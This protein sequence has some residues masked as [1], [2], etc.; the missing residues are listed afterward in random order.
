MRPANRLFRLV[1][2]L[3]LGGLALGVCMV[4]LTPGFEKIAGSAQYSGK[5]GPRLRAL[6]DP[7]TF[8][9]ANGAVYERVG[10]LDRQPVS[11]AAVP[12]VMRQA[13]ISTE[14]RTFYTNDGIDVR[15]AVRALVSDVG[16]GGIDQGGSTITQQ[17]I[18]NRFFKNP[19]RNI[20]R[21]VREAIL[22]HRLT[23]EWSKNRILE[24]YLN[25]VYFG[26][27]SYG[28]Q[29]ASTRI[30]GKPDLAQITLP[31][32]ALLAGLIKNPSAYDIF[33]TAKQKSALER[34]NDVIRRML[35]QHVITKGEAAAARIAPLPAPPRP[36]NELRTRTPY[37]EEV[38]SQLKTLD[39]LGKDP[40]QR[41]QAIF[42]GGL[43]VYTEY[44]P[45]L[46]EMA[47][48]AIAST[49]KPSFAPFTAAMAV[50]DP[51]T[52][53]VRAVVGG[54]GQ[55]Q[56]FN[57]ATDGGGFKVGSTFKP[58]TLATAIEN[59]YSPRDTVDG[60]DS[61]DSFGG[62]SGC[63]IVYDPW[64]KD[65]YLGHNAGDGASGGVN[66]LYYQ[67]RN[68]VNCAYLRLLTSVGPPKVQAMAKTLGYTHPVNN[69]RVIGIGETEHTPLEVATVYSTLADD[70]VK[71]APVFVRRVED[72]NGRVVYRAPG[73]VRVLSTQT[74]R[75]VTDVLSHV[76]EGTAPRA[77]LADRPLAGKTGTVD[78]QV[79]AWFAGYTPQLAAAVWMGNP[80]VQA[81]DNPVAWM[82]HVG[83]FSPVYG[84]TYPAIIWQK[85][86]TTALKGQPVIP[87]TAPDESLWPKPANVIP[88]GGRGEAFSERPPVP[89]APTSSTLPT[90]TTLPPTS[91]PSSTP[92]T[93]GPPPST[94]PKPPGP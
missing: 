6:E 18:K 17:L 74:A 68:S 53:S 45:R 3:V 93:S 85:F 43:R 63:K 57:L 64:G 14:D 20:D 82:S 76:T 50:M 90:N 94:A 19:K 48:Y 31:E 34:R 44:D 78:R 36:D 51:K 67:T 88:K 84:G 30:I 22:A 9:D 33:D 71:H 75:T 65:T 72:G 25:T 46:T 55:A 32:A 69:N 37:G 91:V 87:F 89:E 56:G 92:P 5:V 49:I 7:T 47:A 4:A 79:D 41:E 8:F 40:L 13:V 38:L 80:Q 1:T 35:V 23:S 2:I 26:E 83:E 60:S 42:S 70:G 52:G 24:E 15:S 59:G 54:G 66:D 81:F 27:N 12:K 77:K 29:A 73:G 28:I 10:Q 21:K 39:A 58:I 86:M 16:A 61:T 11:L 62:K